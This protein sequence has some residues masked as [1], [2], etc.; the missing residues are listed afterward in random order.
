MMTF[1][2]MVREEAWKDAGDDWQEEETISLRRGVA[3]E[4]AD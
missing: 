2:A 1:T 4:A 3:R